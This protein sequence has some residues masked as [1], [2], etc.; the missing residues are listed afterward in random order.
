MIRRK[1]EKYGVYTKILY[2]HSRWNTIHWK[3]FGVKQSTQ[4]E[5]CRI[6]RFYWGIYQ[7]FSHPST[8]IPRGNNTQLFGKCFFK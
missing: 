6:F 1:E 5:Y 4:Y 3:Y 2:N 8:N 7:Q